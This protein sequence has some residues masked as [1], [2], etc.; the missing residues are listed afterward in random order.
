MDFNL[1]ISTL[2]GGGLALLAFLKMSN[3][4]SVNR[5]ANFYFG[6][7]CLLWA[8]F[9]LDNIIDREFLAANYALAIVLKVSQFL[10]GVVF[11]ISVR[12]YTNPTLRFSKGDLR[13]LIA[14]I[15]FIALLLVRPVFAAYDVMYVILFQGHSLV[16]ILLSW[17]TVNKHEK[18]IE[19][20]ASDIE[21]IDLRWIKYI[22]Y[23]LVLSVVVVVVYKILKMK[24]PLNF[25]INLHLLIVVYFVAFFSIRQKEIFPRGLKIEDAIGLSDIENSD[26]V[27][28]TK[29]MNDDE[30][31]R[32][33]QNLVTQIEASALYLDCELNLVKLAD[34]M[35]LSTHQLSYVINNGTGE[36]FFNFINRFRVKKAETLLTDPNFDHLTIVAIGF[37][38][39]FNSKTAFNTA[40]KKVTA[41]T[42]TEFRKIRTTFQEK[43]IIN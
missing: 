6:L 19:L 9:W 24:Q 12:F 13:M 40:F 18:N 26:P 20:F 7:V 43:L 36:N 5:K 22:I 10:T 11:F 33:K 15:L 42:P 28:K 41:Y 39:G 2:I 30:L 37:D 21:S 32:T 14:P 1:L 8:S 25:Y 35:R 17:R 23:S 29:L 27:R 38:S 4:L 3:V 16:F 31:L 34:A